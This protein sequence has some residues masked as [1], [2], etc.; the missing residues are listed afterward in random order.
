MEK[1]VI[2]ISKDLFEDLL[3]QYW[4]QLTETLV[5]GEDYVIKEVKI[6]DEFFKDDE[7]YKTLKSE[8]SK[9]YKK[10]KEYEYNKRNK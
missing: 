2:E 9:A 3:H 7:T 8:A 1:L 5:A 4:M 6:T 10:L